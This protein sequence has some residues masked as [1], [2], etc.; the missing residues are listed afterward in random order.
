MS[1]DCPVPNQVKARGFPWVACHN[2]PK[3]SRTPLMPGLGPARVIKIH[4]FWLHLTLP[5]RALVMSYKG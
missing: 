5:P 2:P 3:W 4:N 1:T